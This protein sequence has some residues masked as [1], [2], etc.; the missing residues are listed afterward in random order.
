[1]EVP[2]GLLKTTLKRGC[3]SGTLVVGCLEGGGG[4]GW[5]VK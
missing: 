3:W 2:G 4:G 5:V 1:M